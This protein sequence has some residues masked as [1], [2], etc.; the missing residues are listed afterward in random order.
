MYLPGEAKEALDS[1]ENLT[2]HGAMSR[3]HFEDGDYEPLT[4]FSNEENSSDFIED[5]ESDSSESNTESEADS[6]ETEPDMDEEMA[7]RSG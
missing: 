6:S 4:A 3:M 7:L 1:K 2:G 5:D